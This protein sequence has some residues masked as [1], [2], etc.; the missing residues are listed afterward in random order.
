MI[1]WGWKTVFRV[2][3]RGVFSCPTCG[4]DRNYERRKAQ[5]FFTLFFIPLIPLKVVGEFVRC[6]YCKN[7]FR[8][9]VLAR[10]TASQFTDLLQN[11]VRGVMVNILRRGGWE[12]PGARAIAVQEI[13]TAGA[14]GYAEPNL[15]QDMQVVPED[16]SQMLG[17]LAGQL[18]DAGR[19][20]LVAGA[21][22]VAAA[23]GPLQPAER[24]VIDAVGAALGMSQAYVAGIVA[25]V[26]AGAVAPAAPAA[27]AWGTG[28]QASAGAGAGGG[29]GAAPVW[30]TGAQPP[31]AAGGAGGETMLIQA[32][33]P[34]QP[35]SMETM[36]IQ[37]PQPAPATGAHD[38]VPPQTPAASGMETMMIQA[39]QP[40]PPASGMETM[41]IQA[42]QPPQDVPPQPASSME[43][44]L[45][46]TA[47]PQPPQTIPAPPQTMIDPSSSME[48][49]A[50][51]LPRPV[52]PA[53]EPTHVTPNDDQGPTGWP[54]PHQQQ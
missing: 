48:T 5:R 14:V 16:L 40:A 28:A 1:V 19:E 35:S 51:P 34:A 13:V 49:M 23:D 30:G 46:P 27:P 42:P 8:D 37:A 25:A 20:A 47:A 24:A 3:G 32:P 54:P 52:A 26:P 53:D 17:S 44:M 7:D 33:Q 4:A 11:T 2:I 22:R 31:V 9:S 21:T 15:A 29:T 45:I 36:L 10:P 6:T 43:T 39:P 38:A 50:I 12:H 18:P 41:L